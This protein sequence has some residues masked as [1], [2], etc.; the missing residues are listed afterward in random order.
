[1]WFVNLL[2]GGLGTI[3]EKLAGIF[4]KTMVD[5]KN[6]EANRQANENN[7]GAAVAQTWV[8]SQTAAGNTRADVQK[9]QGTWGPFGI[10]GF[11]IAM[12]F[13]CHVAAIVGDSMPFHL[14]LT[15]KFYVVPWLQWVDHA[16]GSWKVAPL[17]GLFEQT[18]HAILQALFYVGPPSAAAVI[19]AKA[20]RR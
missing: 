9:A 8:N 17:P 14:A 12:A 16:V 7:S 20:F 3:V 2:T 13:A 6:T 15:T 4:G 11:I 10:A 18:E 1:M 19:V 5:L